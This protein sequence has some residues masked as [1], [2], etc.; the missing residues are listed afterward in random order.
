MFGMF[1]IEKGDI[2]YSV[3]VLVRLLKLVEDGSEDN[4]DFIIKILVIC[5]QPSCIHV[6]V[7]NEMNGYLIIILIVSVEI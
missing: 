2:S 5:F 4:L 7:R 3:S 6:R 1:C